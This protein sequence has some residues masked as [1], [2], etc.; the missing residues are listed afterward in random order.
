MLHI[1]PPIEIKPE[2]KKTEAEL[3]EEELNEFS[4]QTYTTP[5]D[6]SAFF[7]EEEYLARMNQSAIDIYNENQKKKSI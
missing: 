1:T 2:V 7:D 5:P 4:N 6:L 3:D